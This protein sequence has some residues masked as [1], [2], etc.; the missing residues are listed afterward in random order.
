M[1]GVGSATL[2]LAQ[3]RDGIRLAHARAQAA[4][5]DNRARGALLR[6]LG[7]MWKIG[8]GAWVFQRPRVKSGKSTG[9]D[10]LLTD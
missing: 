8:T 7:H 4:R 10:F 5:E 9:A 6:S 1:P 2:R 3:R